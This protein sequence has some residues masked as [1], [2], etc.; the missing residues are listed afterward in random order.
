MENG[1]AVDSNQRIKCDF[2]TD[3]HVDGKSGDSVSSWTRDLIFESTLKALV[4]NR[5]VEKGLENSQV[6]SLVS[7]QM[8]THEEQKIAQSSLKSKKIVQ[9]QK[10]WEKRMAKY[11]V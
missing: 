2:L 3:S 8:F 10:F 7:L 9:E 6:W 5:K 4:H 1:G 11:A